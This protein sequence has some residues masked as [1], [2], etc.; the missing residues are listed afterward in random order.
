MGPFEDGG[1]E[2]TLLPTISSRQIGPRTQL[3]FPYK[4]SPEPRGRILFFG[5]VPVLRRRA[6]QDSDVD[7]GITFVSFLSEYTW[8]LSHRSHHF[9]DFWYSTLHFS[10]LYLVDR[11]AYT[12]PPSTLCDLDTIYRGLMFDFGCHPLPSFTSSRGVFLP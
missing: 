1:G 2:G 9:L 3:Y 12:P 7:S 4:E 11:S 10:P 5:K 6:H 8:V